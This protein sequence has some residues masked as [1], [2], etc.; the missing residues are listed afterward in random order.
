VVDAGCVAS[1]LASPMLTSRVNSLQRVLE[2]RAAVAAAL[3]AEREDA[4]RAAGQV[5]RDERMIGVIEPA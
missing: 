5:A 4:G 1:D 3:D 2:F